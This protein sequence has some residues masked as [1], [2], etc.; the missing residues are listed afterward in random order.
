[1]QG[2]L[3]WAAL[4]GGLSVAVAAW[5]QSAP[6]DSGEVSR[7]V[8]EYEQREAQFLADK[9]AS[10]EFDMTRHPAREY[11]PKFRALAE[12][13]AH[14]AEALPALSWLASNGSAEDRTWALDVLEREHVGRPE[15][16]Q[17]LRDL[18]FEGRAVE[19]LYDAVLARNKDR[20]VL[21]RAMVQKGNMLLTDWAAPDETLAVRQKEALKLFRKVVD[22][23]GGTKVAKRAE[24][25]IF[26][27][28]KL[29]VGMKAPDLVGKDADGKEIRLS[30]YRGRVVVLAFW[31]YW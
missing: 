9:P 30:D 13:Y 2:R 5:A 17:V 22:E 8:Q 3:R 20:E 28:E 31:G 23:Y 24:S 26:D 4:L 1:M 7:L 29:Q 27:I 11:R 15:I 19:R 14:Q 12:K 21:A 16:V 25:W 6:A 18:Q 10:G